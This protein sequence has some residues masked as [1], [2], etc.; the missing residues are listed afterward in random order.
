M[1]GKHGFTKTAQ[2]VRSE[3]RAMPVKRNQHKQHLTC[4]YVQKEP[5]DA[6]PIID[7][8]DTPDPIDGDKY[9]VLSSHLLSTIFNQMWFTFI[10]INTK[11]VNMDKLLRA[12]RVAEI[13]DLSERY[14]YQ[15]ASEGII[16]CVRFGSAVRFRQS[17]IEAWVEGQTYEGK[18]MR[19]LKTVGAV[20]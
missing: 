17:E 1:K 20:R 8:V 18:Q 10:N 5:V 12:G 6:Y 2:E 7:L 19:S 15:L 14:V 13:L 3:N 9:T 16:P 11:E 4:E